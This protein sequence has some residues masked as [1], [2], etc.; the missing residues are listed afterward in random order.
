MNRFAVALRLFILTSFFFPACSSPAPQNS[1]SPTLI[2]SRSASQS[3]LNST[4][5]PA[6]HIIAVRQVDGAGEF[7]D[8]QTDQKFIPRGANYV[9]VPLGDVHTI[10]LL[11]VGLYD[12]RRTRADFAQLAGLGYNTVRVFLDQ[13]GNGT[14]C[15]GDDDNVGLN[16]AYLDN[17]ADMLLAARESRIFILFTSNDLP[18]QGGYSEEAN[19][20]SS[21]NFAGYRN[22]YYLTP[23]AIAATRRYWRDLLTGL[24]ERNAAFDAVL[25]WELLN[26]Q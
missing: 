1:P 12:P 8:K 5:A 21:Q 20:G 26:E 17:I 6:E 16:P 23:Q 7:Y 3:T 11:K 9:Y 4:Q 18:D 15:I 24:V 22:S 25:G 2:P 13:C 14:G 10:L 19:A